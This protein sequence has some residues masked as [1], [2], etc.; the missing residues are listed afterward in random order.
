MKRSLKIS[1]KTP[2]K[3]LDDALRYLYASLV[4]LEVPI[5]AIRFKY[6]G[7]EWSVDTAEEADAVR[8]QMDQSIP[9]AYD[10]MDELD[11]FWT[12]DRFMDV[13]NGIGKLQ[14]RFLAA[15]YEK[16]GINSGELS[17]KLGLGSEIALAG[18]ISGL[19][20]QLKQLG[21]EPKQV[22]IIDVKW[23]KKR[24]A[25]TFILNDFFKSAGMELKWPQAWAQEIGVIDEI[26]SGTL[27]GDD[28]GVGD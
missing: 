24:K 10:T 11:R 27:A 6:R 17:E 23:K 28:S 4:Y 3:R 19:S 14:H 2:D 13:I 25:R 18:V 20:K 22:F 26:G 16:A 15:I 7:I 21:I 9:L 5:V 1:T 12:H 8:K